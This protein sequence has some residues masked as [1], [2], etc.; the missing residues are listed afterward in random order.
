MDPNLPDDPHGYDPDVWLIVDSID[1]S[2]GDFWD[3]VVL[4]A[5]G[6]KVESVHDAFWIYEDGS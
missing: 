2:S 1:W 3:P 6:Y 5:K 4:H